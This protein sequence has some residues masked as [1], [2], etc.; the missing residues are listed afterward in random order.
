MGYIFWDYSRLKTSGILER[1]RYE[2]EQH[3]YAEYR[4]DRLSVQERLM[5]R[6]YSDYAER[7]QAKREEP[8]GGYKKENGEDEEWFEAELGDCASR[9]EREW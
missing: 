4:P 9:F 1:D 3:S 6:P 5:G 8:E 7:M 2:I